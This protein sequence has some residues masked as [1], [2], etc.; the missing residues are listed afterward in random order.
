M[1]NIAD[2]ETVANGSFG[3]SAPTATKAFS[4]D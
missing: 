3:F 4:N 1:N 2:E